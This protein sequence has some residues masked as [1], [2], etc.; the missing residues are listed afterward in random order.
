MHSLL[1]PEHLVRTFGYLG[2]LL[3][4]FCES[5]II[6][7]FFL[8]GDSLL[9][10]AGLLASQHYLNLLGIIVVAVIGAVLG[11]NAGYYTGKK[12]GPALFTREDSLFFSRR[13]VT[14]AHEFFE[15]QGGKALV[16]ARFIPAGRTLVPIIAGVGKMNYRHFFMYNALGGLLWAILMPVLGYSLGKSVPNIDKYVLPVILV[17]IILSALPVL[18]HY[19]KNRKRR[20][21]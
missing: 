14:E 21:G 10:T 9:F 1:N 19:N 7:G 2:I 11:N 6:F 3:T 4:I 13:R 16:L 5:G 8:P 20:H 18:Y 12:T 17:I 15:R